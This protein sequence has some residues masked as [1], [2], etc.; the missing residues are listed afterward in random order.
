MW[1]SAMHDRRIT[2]PLMEPL[3]L[4]AQALAAAAPVA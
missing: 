1:M 3:V 2:M 4:P